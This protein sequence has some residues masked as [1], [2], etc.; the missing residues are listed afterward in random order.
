MTRSLVLALQ[1]K[2]RNSLDLH[3]SG[4]WLAGWVILQLVL[5]LHIL[6]LKPRQRQVPRI[7]MIVSIAGLAVA[8]HAPI[9]W[10]LLRHT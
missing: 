2:P 5:R 10:S 4:V 7:D 3:P 1:G 8:I 6:V 9:I